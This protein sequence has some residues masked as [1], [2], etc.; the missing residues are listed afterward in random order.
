MIYSRLG[1]KTLNAVR[2]MIIFA[3]FLLL[4][5]S[6]SPLKEGNLGICLKSSVGRLRSFVEK[7][8]KEC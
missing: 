1:A 2:N 4:L 8:F 3:T 5:F 7:A 6:F